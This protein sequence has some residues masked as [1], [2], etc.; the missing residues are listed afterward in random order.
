MDR[1]LIWTERASGDI[2]A[3]VR[4]SEY[5]SQSIGSRSRAIE[6]GLRTIEVHLHTISV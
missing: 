3:I 6:A 2:E 5:R 4:Y 1:K